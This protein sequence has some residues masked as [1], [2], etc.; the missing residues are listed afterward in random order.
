MTQSERNRLYRE[1]NH[2]KTRNAVIEWHKRHPDYAKKY[3]EDHKER[4]KFL[5]TKWQRE[6]PGYQRNYLAP[7]AAKVGKV[8]TPKIH[9]DRLSEEE[10]KRRKKERKNQWQ[11][12]HYASNKLLYR[13]AAREQRRIHKARYQATQNARK[14][15]LRCHLNEQTPSEKKAVRDFYFKVRTD[16]IVVCHWCNS[17]I[18]KGERTVDHFIPL[19]R[20]GRHAVAN[21][22]ACCF[23]CNREKHDM[24]PDEYVEFRKRKSAA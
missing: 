5:V 14:A 22:V 2:E 8:Y 12:K 13:L 15:L 19:S 18:P 24:L 16:D 3:R 20:E 21:L 4:I 7:R 6:H 9:R 1:K 10:K 23:G 17:L 11:K